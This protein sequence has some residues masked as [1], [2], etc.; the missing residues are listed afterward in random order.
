MTNL[1]DSTPLLVIKPQKPKKKTKKRKYWPTKE[2]H[3]S[4]EWNITKVYLFGD[5]LTV[6]VLICSPLPTL[7]S[8][9]ESPQPRAL[10][11]AE[12]VPT[13]PPTFV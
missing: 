9:S 5:K 3:N 11:L 1:V 6:R 2:F 12:G 4:P 13:A 10:L 7:G 8:G